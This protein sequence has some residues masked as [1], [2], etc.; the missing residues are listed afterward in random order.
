[1]GTMRTAINGKINAMF[2]VNWTSQDGKVNVTSECFLG[3]NQQRHVCGHR[4]HPLRVHQ[5][6]NV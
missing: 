5:D 1:M 6:V 2:G 3:R 4:E